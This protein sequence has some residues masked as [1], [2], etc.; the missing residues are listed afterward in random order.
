[1]HK[2]IKLSIVIISL[3]FF[4]YISYTYFMSSDVIYVSI[5]PSQD[6]MNITAQLTS[7]GIQNSITTSNN[8]SNDYYLFLPSYALGKK[9]SF[10][11]S[12]SIT[13]DPIEEPISGILTKNQSYI[14]NEQYMLHI[15]TGSDI[16]AIYLKTKHDLS[17]ISS[18]KSISDS[19]QATILTSNGEVSY[20]GKLEKINGRGNNS[21]G[22]E[23]KPF[24]I[25]LEKDVSLYDMKTSNEYSLIASSDF[26]F[27]RNKI[28]D[29]MA[30]KLDITALK[31]QHIDLYINGEYQGIYELCEKITADTLN[32]SDIETATKESLKRASTAT[33]ITSGEHLQDW[34]NTITGKWWNWEHDDTVKT[35]GGYIL[36]ADQAIRYDAEPSGFTLDSGAYIVSKEPSYLTEAQYNY[37]S[38]YVQECENNM[39][40]SLETGSIETLSTYI[41]I[42]SFVAKYLIEEISKNID[43]SSTSQYFYINADG[44]LTAGPVWDYDWAY[45]VVRTEHDIDFNQPTGFSTRNVPGSLIWWQ[46]LYY[47]NSFYNEVVRTYNNILYPYLMEL[48]NT[49]LCE[50]ETALTESAVMDYLKWNR[51]TS[52]EAARKEY[53]NQ[54]ES[55][56]TFIEQRIEF[57]YDEWNP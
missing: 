23:K 48:T 41:D 19:G 20:I 46:I 9:I 39:F 24:S 25:T 18:D 53:H 4:I 47:N 31:R 49:T 38:S 14:L 50:W 51:A 40:Q 29:S 22:K 32:I 16:P 30:N 7:S 3:C 10:H 56:S 17:Y 34:N 11:C 2:R 33:Q 27:L 6:S 43:C 26:T 21:W 28:S 54:V 1:M 57:L 15:L 55:M 42:P 35:S 44:L 45:G 13:I 52:E 5:F 37:I 12:D 36:E 8:G